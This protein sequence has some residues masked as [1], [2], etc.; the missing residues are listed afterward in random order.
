MLDFLRAAR[1]RVEQMELTDA[2]AMR[3]SQTTTAPVST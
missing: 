3:F 2:A 1:E